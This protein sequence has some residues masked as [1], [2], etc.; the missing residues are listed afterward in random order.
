GRRQPGK[1]LMV[2]FEHGRI[3]SAEQLKRELAAQRPYQDWLDRTQIRLE[4]IDKPHEV[5][6]PDTDKLLDR[7]QA[8]GYTQEDLKMLLAPMALAGEEAIG[9]MGD[10]APLAVLSDRAKPLYS[11][12]RQLF[13]QVTN[14]PID[15]IREQLVMSLVSFIGPR[16]N[17]ARRR[18]RIGARSAPLRVP[19]G[20]RR[21]G[22]PSQPR[23]RHAPR[24]ARRA[25]AENRREGDRQALYQ[26]DR[27]GIAEGDVEDGHLDLP[28]VLRRADLRGGGTLVGVRGQVLHRHTHRDR[29]RGAAR[30]RRG[31]GAPAPARLFR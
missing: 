14:P 2:D 7:Q 1:M 22:D 8:F 15:P 6:T 5:P 4:D 11:Y 29:G 17:G 26:G 24:P 12:F 20:L 13:A 25:A 23:L 27:Q 30:D 3:V 31:G 21:R 18:D 9:S 28:V 10:D 19:R 16:P